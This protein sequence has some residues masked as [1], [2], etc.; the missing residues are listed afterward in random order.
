M[1]H[2]TRTAVLFEN[3]GYRHFIKFRHGRQ[4]KTKRYLVFIQ[5]ASRRIIFLFRKEKVCH[6]NSGAY[7]FTNT[8][9]DAVRG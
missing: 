4:S 1:Q 6:L 9:A 3:F 2:W 7:C 8:L 5:P